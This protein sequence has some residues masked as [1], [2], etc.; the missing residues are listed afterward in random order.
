[1]EGLTL[2]GWQRHRLLSQ[3]KQA[4]EARVY[5]RILAVLEVN[6]GKSIAEVADTLGVTRQSVYNWIEHYAQTYDGHTLQEAERPGRPRLWTGESDGVLQALLEAV[7]EQSGYPGANWTVPLLQEQ[8]ERHLGRRYSEDT[9]R[10]GLRGLGYVWKRSRYVLA[11]D[12]E[13]GKKG[14]THSEASEGA[15]ASPRDFG[16]R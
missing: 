4:H 8:L 16:G 13:R 3:L 14:A 5:R 1:M 12:P 7:P 2:T 6:N 15:G 9:V 10:R 11:P